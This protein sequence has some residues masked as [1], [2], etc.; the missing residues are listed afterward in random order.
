VAVGGSPVAG[1]SSGSLICS[2]FVKLTITS[3]GELGPG[4]GC[5]IEVDANDLPC[6]QRRAIEVVFS[7]QALSTILGVGTTSHRVKHHLFATRL[8]FSAPWPAS[9]GAKVYDSNWTNPSR[10]PKACDTATEVYKGVA[11]GARILAR[12]CRR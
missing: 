8:T 2:K 7:A 3:P 9:A 12:K 4:W 6:D 10:R 1:S 11:V 5:E